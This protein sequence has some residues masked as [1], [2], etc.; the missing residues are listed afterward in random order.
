M[1]NSGGTGFDRFNAY[2][3]WAQQAIGRLSFCLRPAE[4]DRLVTT[5]R[6]WLLQGL[7]P[8]TRANSLASLVDLEAVQVTGR[9][10]AAVEEFQSDLLRWRR[11]GRVVVPDTNVYLHHPTPFDETDWHQVLGTDESLRIV[12][13]LVIVDELDRHKHSGKQEVRARARVTLKAID[14]LLP[15][16]QEPVSVKLANGSAFRFEMLLDP[17][18]HLRLPSADDEIVDRVAALTPLLD[19]PP[20]L[21][22][23]DTGAALR[24]SVGGVARFKLTHEH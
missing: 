9:L 12:V 21:V 11:P 3:E 15:D 2:N 6:H 13:P 5:S 1:R 22:T 4:I 7:D 17:L 14:K 20:L 23:Y 8:A 18:G 24:A 19:N 10:S 16:P